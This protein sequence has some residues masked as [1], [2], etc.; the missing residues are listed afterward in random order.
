MGSKIRSRSVVVYQRG[1]PLFDFIVDIS[2]FNREVSHRATSWDWNSVLLGFVD[3]GEQ[4][5]ELW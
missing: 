5:L 2:T 3:K 1:G 4:K